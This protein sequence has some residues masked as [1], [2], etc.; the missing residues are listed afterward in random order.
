MPVHDALEAAIVVTDEDG[1]VERF[2]EKPTWGQVF[3]DTINTGIFVLEPEIF[4]FI[5]PG[6]P[7]DFS[8]EVFP[9]LLAKSQPVFGA[10]AEGYWEDVGTLEV[11]PEERIEVVAALVEVGHEA[12]KERLFL[13]ELVAV[14]NGPADDSPQH[15]P[16]ALVARN[17]AVDDEERAGADMVGD[18]AQRDVVER[19]VVAEAPRDVC[20]LERRDGGGRGG[21]HGGRGR[22]HAVPS[23]D[24]RKAWTEARSFAQM[25]SKTPRSRV[26][27]RS[28]RIP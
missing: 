13:S 8:G 23:N 4:D 2:L 26:A 14:T 5:E 22:D 20:G 17:Y 15:I 11:V 16:A 18:H 7:V 3:S 27:R 28:C 9:A 1:R 25:Y 24:E 21:A 12:V 6:R 10:V 19:G